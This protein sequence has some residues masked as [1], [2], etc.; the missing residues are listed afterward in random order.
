MKQA[1]KRAGRVWIAL[2]V[3]LALTCGSAFIPL[4]AWNSV[5]NLVIAAIKALLVALFFMHLREARPAYRLV[6]IAGL[7]TFALLVSLSLADYS[8]RAQFPAPWQS[9][10][11]R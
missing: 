10:P 3:L 1:W 8:T 4:G 7:F 6:A 2:L 11:A 9:P 5:T